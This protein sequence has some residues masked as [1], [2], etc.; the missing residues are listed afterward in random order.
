MCGYFLGRG[1]V[2]LVLGQ[3]ADE[4][5]LAGRLP[6]ERNVLK[7]PESPRSARNGAGGN[8]RVFHATRPP[9]SATELGGDQLSK[10]GRDVCHR[11]I[12]SVQAASRAEQGA[13]FAES[14][15]RRAVHDGNEQVT[16]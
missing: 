8:I 14:F 11:L 12:F 1:T 13:D 5:L 3:L 15:I 4:R 9:T 10:L 7:A 6:R 16:R 2:T